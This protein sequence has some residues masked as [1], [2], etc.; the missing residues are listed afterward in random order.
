MSDLLTGHVAVAATHAYAQSALPDAPVAAVRRRWR[1]RLR[2][3]TAWALR[4]L[5]DRLAAA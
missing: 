2:R 4:R 5:A 1:P 3:G